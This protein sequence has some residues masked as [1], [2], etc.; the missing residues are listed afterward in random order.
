M[1]A[2]AQTALVKQGSILSVSVVIALLLFL[3]MHLLIRP[4]NTLIKGDDT[5]TYLNF[6]RVDSSEQDVKTK[7]RQPPREPPEP[8]TPPDTPDMEVSS[9]QSAASNSLSMNMPSIGLSINAGDGAF[10][11]GLTPGD[12]FAGFDTDV[13]PLV[14]VPPTYPRNALMARIQGS[15]TMEVIIDP[16]GTVSSAKVIEATPARLFNSAALYA[17]KRWKFRPKIVNGSPVA[18][19]ARQTID[20]KL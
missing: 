15:V 12:G 18:Q 3:L 6:V 20:F 5:H 9:Q 19:R 4:D 17:I 8:D 10:L 7:K 11:G 13:I 1:A 2:L 14:R 16:D